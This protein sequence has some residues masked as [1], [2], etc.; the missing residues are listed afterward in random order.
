MKNKIFTFRYQPHAPSMG[1]A[2]LSAAKSKKPYI[3]S[4]ELICSDLKNLLQIATESRLELFGVIL[5]EKPSSL[6]E[7][8]SLIN[9]NQSYVLKEARVLESLGL[10]ELVAELDGARQKLRPRALYSK[11][12][13]D[14]GFETKKTGTE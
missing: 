2:L 1:K 8:A 9:K 7:L 14:C 12:L 3:S 13:I 11:I 4:D 5:K 6:Y 10:I